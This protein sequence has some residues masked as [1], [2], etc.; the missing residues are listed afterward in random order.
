MPYQWATLCCGLVRNEEDQVLGVL[1]DS[2]RYT[3][4]MGWMVMDQMVSVNEQIPLYGVGGFEQL[5]NNSVDHKERIERM[6]RVHEEMEEE[7]HHTN[8]V[9]YW[10]RMELEEWVEWLEEANA[11][12]WLGL[13]QSIVE[14]Q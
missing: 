13:H 9:V 1:E 10:G 7:I 12:H 6:E 14:S 3:T 5:C 2:M 4:T 8:N 11:E